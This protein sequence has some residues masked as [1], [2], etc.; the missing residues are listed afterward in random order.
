MPYVSGCKLSPDCFNGA[1][2]AYDAV[3]FRHVTFTGARSTP[4]AFDRPK[5]KLLMHGKTFPRDDDDDKKK[6]MFQVQSNLKRQ[7]KDSSG[8]M[9]YS[10]VRRGMP[11]NDFSS[12]LMRLNMKTS[13]F[14]LDGPTSPP[15]DVA[16]VTPALLSPPSRHPSLFFR[17]SRSTA[18]AHVCPQAICSTC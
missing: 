10:C 3:Q 14:V 2:P 12:L 4:T 15:P 6:G 7:L 8:M 17:I 13:T 1:T 5:G 18:D 16:L 11:G 9:F